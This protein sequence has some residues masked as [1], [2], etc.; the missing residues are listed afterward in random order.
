MSYRLLKPAMR[1]ASRMTDTFCVNS[2]G[3]VLNA[4][5]QRALG[6]SPRSHVALF[7]NDDGFLCFMPAKEGDEGARPLSKMGKEK[8]MLLAGRDIARRCARGRYRITGREGAFHVTDCH[9]EEK[10]VVE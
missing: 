6:I 7:V 10:E 2:R 8:S 1:G 9:L 5:M 4:K 3:I